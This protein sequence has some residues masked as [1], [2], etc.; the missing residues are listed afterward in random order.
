M[1]RFNTFTITITIAVASMVFSITVMSGGVAGAASYVKNDGTIV[2]PILDVNGGVH[3]YSGPNLVAGVPASGANLAEADLYDG[4]LYGADLSGANLGAANLTL[5]FM[6]NANLA[7]AN[8]S[9]SNLS[10]ADLNHA[11]LSG[12]N[13]GGTN[14]S[15]ANLRTIFSLDTVIGVPYYS[16]TTTFIDLWTGIGEETPF[17]P[18]A[19]GW[20]LVPEPNT[21]LLLGIGLS[22]LAVRREKR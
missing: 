22:A 13:L 5:A 9:L 17:D 19:A 4:H 15:G 16:S 1:K 2:D 6:E 11:D 18:V 14:L 20:T 12:A 7:G 8:L 3:T 21:A 10:G